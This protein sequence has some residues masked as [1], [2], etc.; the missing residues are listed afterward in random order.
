MCH[1]CH[2]WHKWKC[3]CISIGNNG[4]MAMIRKQS[5]RVL[6][7]LEV[8]TDVIIRIYSNAFLL[9]DC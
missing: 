2:K 9:I 4:I 7:H 3:D 6:L 5:T 1:M 8:E